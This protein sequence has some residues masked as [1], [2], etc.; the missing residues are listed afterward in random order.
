MTRATDRFFGIPASDELRTASRRERDWTRLELVPGELEL[1]SA[2]INLPWLGAVPGEPLLQARTDNGELLTL[3]ARTGDG[4]EL[5][6]DVDSA[7][8]ALIDHRALTPGRPLASRL[9]FHYHRVPAPIRRLLRD[10][11]TR[12]QADSAEVYPGWPQEPSVEA[13]RTIYLRARQLLDPGLRPAPFWPDGR[14]FALALTHD[15]DT[16]PGLEISPQIAAD[17]ADRGLKS[18]WYLV[19]RAYPLDGAPIEALR[20]GGHELGLHDAL[21]DNKLAF[22]PPAEMAARLDSCRPDMERLGMKGF[23]SPSMMRTSAL[24]EVLKLRFGYDSSMPDTGLLPAR[25]GCATVFPFERQ[26]MPVLPLTIPPDGQLLGRG[27]EPGEVLA[28]WIAKTQWI[29]EWGGGAVHLTHP[30]PGFTHEEPMR[31]AYRGY[32][33]WAAGLGDAWHVLPHA[34]MEHW[35]ERMAASETL[36]ST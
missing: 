29:R 10:L 28:A 8:E 9:P 3:A 30:D 31:D 26:G 16:P 12:R 13:V 5:A 11:L 18:C 32:L 4:I 7:V 17:E 22:M 35:R 34:L 25:N 24:Y 20:Q 1:P 19:A 33:D 21:H 36:S 2:T 27:N 23:R 6:F 15:V 14:R